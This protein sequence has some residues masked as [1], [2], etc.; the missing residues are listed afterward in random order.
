MQKKASADFSDK[1]LRGITLKELSRIIG[2][3]PGTV[4]V[5][6][7][8]TARAET[9]PQKTKDRILQAAEEH[10]YR[11]HY[12]AR[13]LRANRSFTIG[14]ITAELSDS[15]CARILNGIEAAATEKGYFYLNTS[16]LHE[17][18]LLVK[19]VQMLVERQVEGIITID[20][21]MRFYSNV[22]IVAVAGHEDIP[23]VT[24][25]VINHQKAAELALDHLVSLGHE[26]IAVI[27]GQDFSADTEIRC[28]AIVKAAAD[29]GLMIDPRRVVQLEGMNP[30][31]EVGYTAAQRLL[32]KT[33]DFTAIFSFNDMS[34]IGAIQALHQNGIR[35]P[36]DV[37]I[38]GFDNIFF[39]E[40]NSPSLTTIRQPL[41][42]MGELAAQTLL[43]R[44]ADPSDGRDECRTLSVE[45]EL[46]VRESTAPANK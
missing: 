37:S 24:N 27:K 4:S 39:A 33:R 11:P 26:K 14:V 38:I 9:I 13:S 16:H 19:N 10:G 8:N 32:A 12:F 36:H 28:D 45:P 44:L 17:E 40:F 1:L 7:N 20:T 3:S 42:E 2:L 18:D 5:V 31:P 6:L 23:G 29:R 21:N 35:V 15:Y 22:P 41:Y 46:I 25:V 43:N 30:S 34:A